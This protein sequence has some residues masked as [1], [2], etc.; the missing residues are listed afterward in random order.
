MDE[1]FSAIPELERTQIDN[2]DFRWEAFPQLGGVVAVSVFYKRFQKP[3]EQIVQP[4]AEVRIT[5]EN[6]G[7]SQQLWRGVRGAPEFRCADTGPE[8]VF[9]QY[10]RRAHL[11]AS[12]A[13]GCRHPDFFGAAAAGA[14]SLHC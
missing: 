11:V 10:Q 8:Q 2:Y 4:Q 6:A 12:R 1:L 3:I 14:V 7:G 5:Y 13:A 9:Y